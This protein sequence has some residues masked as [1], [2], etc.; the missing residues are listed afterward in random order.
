MSP[1]LLLPLAIVAALIGLWQ[2]ASEWD[3][4][5][6]ALNIEDFLVPSPSQIAQSLWEERS[7]LA[8]NAWVTLKEVVLGFALAVVLGLTFAVAMHLSETLRRALYALVVAS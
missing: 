3:L 7:L 5:A 8:D 1:F 6:N 4:I 2:L